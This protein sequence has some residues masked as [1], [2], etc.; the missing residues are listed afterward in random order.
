M[1]GDRGK[2]TD[3]REKKKKTGS[4]TFCSSRRNV[5]KG[6]KGN[7][8]ELPVGMW[9]SLDVSSTLNKKRSSCL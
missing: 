9:Y 2:L 5:N 6:D 1:L 4:S 7:T 8:S 3:A